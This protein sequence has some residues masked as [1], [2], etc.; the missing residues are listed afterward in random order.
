MRFIRLGVLA[1]ILWTASA[2]PARGDTID[3]GVNILWNGDT[4]H[5][6]NGF[7]GDDSGYTL[8]NSCLLVLCSQNYFDFEV[9][10]TALAE[11]GVSWAD[12]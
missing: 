12:C 4:S 2:P 6:A 7:W 9:D 3:F 11:S 5:A 1:T 8:Q 10:T